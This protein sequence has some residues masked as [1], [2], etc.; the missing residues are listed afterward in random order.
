MK[1]PFKLVCGAAVLA[2]LIVAG[3]LF[4][5]GRPVAL[6]PELPSH[7]ERGPEPPP[8]G[9]PLVSRGSG[10]A[11]VIAAEASRLAALPPSLSRDAAVAA[12]IADLADPGVCASIATNLPA[13][14][15]SLVGAA[16]RRWVELDAPGAIHEYALAAPQR[17]FRLANLGWMFRDYAEQDAAAALNFAKS[18]TGLTETERHSSVAATLPALAR[19]NPDSAIAELRDLPASIA[20]GPA[21]EVY[22]ELARQ[23]SAAD[24]FGEASELQGVA[25]ALAQQAVIKVAAAA[26][27]QAAVQLW[28]SAD[29][30]ARHDLTRAL[31]DGF[32]DAGVE[33]KAM[34][35]WLLQ[36]AP[37]RGADSVR[38][39]ALSRLAEQDAASAHALLSQQP[40]GQRDSLAAAVASMLDPGAGLLFARQISREDQR[41]TAM[42]EVASR[43]ASSDP[44]QLYAEVGKDPEFARAALSA[45]VDALVYEDSARATTYVASLPADL[46]GEAAIHL[47][48]RVSDTSPDR[49]ITLAA[50][51]IPD[52]DARNLGV[53]S[54]YAAAI[55]DQSVSRLQ[56]LPPIPD[57]VDCDQVLAS[58]VPLVSFRNPEV[59][60]SVASSIADDSLRLNAIHEVFVA[61]AQ[62]ES[63]EHARQRLA[64]AGLPQAIADQ[65]LNQLPPIQ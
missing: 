50:A 16:L 35:E 21:Y 59:A 57:G 9:P 5:P 55:V 65:I 14:G 23:R 26:D 13:F 6:P 38:A 51:L 30:A 2:A 19:T 60:W 33:P 32:R 54:A 15:H 41:L 3:R 4:W 53:A 64:S 20:G 42:A 58:V 48:E 47:V 40:P 28:F 49:A 27:P 8:L 25:R 43:L 17:D 44:A 18:L 37:E 39:E 31:A 63:P 36:H 10:T 62:V 1:L 11:S 22:G 24:V 45:V 52:P 46:R 12:F 56:Q 61:I 29:T 7:R 34:A